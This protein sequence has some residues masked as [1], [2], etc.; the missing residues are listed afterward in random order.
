MAESQQNPAVQLRANVRAAEKA[1][2][3][4]EALEANLKKTF[5][6]DPSEKTRSALRS[7]SAERER[8]EAALEDA[9]AEL[10]NHADDEREKDPDDPLP[11]T[12]Y[13]AR[14]IVAKLSHYRQR[15]TYEAVGGLRKADAW[16]VRGWFTGREAPDNSFI[17]KKSTGEPTDYPAAKV[18]PS[19]KSRPEILSTSDELLAWLQSHPL[20][21]R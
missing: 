21:I 1:L 10:E 5:G 15:A 16:K 13:L 19:L 3:E 7:A 18:H 12:D 14:E 9:R 2:H 6:T 8:A 17:V 11:Q 4:A 20:I